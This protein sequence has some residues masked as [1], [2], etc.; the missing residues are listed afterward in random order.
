[1][2]TAE[3]N[4]VRALYDEARIAMQQELRAKMARGKMAA[5]V[6]FSTGIFPRAVSFWPV[7]LW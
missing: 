3:Q 4:Y 2:F 1:M 6:F 5:R 7:L